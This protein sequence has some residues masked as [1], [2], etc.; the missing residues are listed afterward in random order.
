MYAMER[1]DERSSASAILA[2]G[3]SSVVKWEDAVWGLCRQVDS[4]P[5]PS[6]DA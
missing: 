1:G 2:I 6:F 3:F 4:P 5:P